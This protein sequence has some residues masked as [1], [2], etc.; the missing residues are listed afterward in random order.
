MTHFNNNSCL[1]PQKHTPSDGLWM[2]WRVG[3]S[4]IH[5]IPSNYCYYCRFTSLAV[6]TDIYDKQVF[7]VYVCYL[8]KMT[9]HVWTLFFLYFFKLCVDAI[10]IKKDVR[11]CYQL[12]S[13]DN[14]SLAT[15]SKMALVQ[16]LVNLCWF[17]LPL[18]V[19]VS[20]CF[21]APARE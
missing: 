15:G 2:G 21:A 5:S 12:I 3:M 20:W 11:Y 9:W 7:C 16:K 1:L 4:V 6:R 19:S 17:E 13:K 8:L 14:Y 18:S 10:M